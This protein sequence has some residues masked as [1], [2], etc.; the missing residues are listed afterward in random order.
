MNLDQDKE[1]QQMHDA[2]IELEEKYGEDVF[3]TLAII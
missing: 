1:E 3:Q 2:T